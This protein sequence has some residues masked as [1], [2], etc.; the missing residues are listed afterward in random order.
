MADHAMTPKQ[1]QEHTERCIDKALLDSNS[2]LFFDR[3]NI[4]PE[5]GGDMSARG[6]ERSKPKTTNQTTTSHPCEVTPTLKGD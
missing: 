4:T 3:C 5:K 2:V 6:A 1:F